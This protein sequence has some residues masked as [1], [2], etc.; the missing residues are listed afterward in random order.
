M[1]VRGVLLDVDGT[2]LDSNG[3]HA[4][5]YA[6]ALAEQGIEVPVA[7]LRA[8]IG[9]GS[10]KLLPAI[11]VK[12]SS[13]LGECIQRRK[14]EIFAERLLPSVRPCRGARGLVLVMKQ[15]G[16]ALSVATSAAAAELHALLQAAH[17]D[18]LVDT[19]STSSDA[20]SSKPDPDIVQAAAAKTGMPRADLAMLGDTPY[21]VEA[22]HKAGVR[23]IALRC[24]GWSDDDLRGAEE[25]YNDPADLLARY[26][27]SLLAT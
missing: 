26:P 1:T 27:E 7:R 4:E 16:L 10:D 3:A 9:M 19:E 20:A 15:H 23:V 18:D 25:I 5:A 11:D 6:Q 17:I 8:L 2:L 12:P 13:P 22:A 14:K 21:D 24:G